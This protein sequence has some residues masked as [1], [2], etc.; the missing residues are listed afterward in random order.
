VTVPPGDPFHIQL[1]NL[2]VIFHSSLTLI[3]LEQRRVVGWNTSKVPKAD[4]RMQL[5]AFYFVNMLLAEENQRITQFH[6]MN[7]EGFFFLLFLKSIHHH[8]N[9][10]INFIFF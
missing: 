1:P 9:L 10:G 5:M 2:E 8:L 7:K 6:L 3:Y 4:V